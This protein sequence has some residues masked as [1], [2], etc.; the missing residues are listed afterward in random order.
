M[1]ALKLLCGASLIWKNPIFIESLH[2]LL[3]FS[4]LDISVCS[5]D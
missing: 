3:G 4:P 2:E 1:I 5:F